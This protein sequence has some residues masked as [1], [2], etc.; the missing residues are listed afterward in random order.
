MASANVDILVN[1][2]N[3]ASGTL[4][5]VKADLSGMDKA[6]GVLTGGI[7]GVAATAGVA[8]VLGLGGAI[9]DLVSKAS[10]VDKIGDSFENL[11]ASAGQSSESMLV[12]LR[13]ASNGMISDGELMLSANKAMMLGVADTAEEMTALLGVARTRGAAMGLSASQAFDNIVTGLGRESALILDNLGIVLDAEK[14]MADYAKTLDKTAQELSSVERKQALVNAVMAQSAGMKAV[15]GGGAG[16]AL[17][18]AQVA[19]EEA[20]VKVGQFMGPAVRDFAQLQVDAINAVQGQWSSLDVAI[21]ETTDLMATAK[22]PEENIAQ[23][24]RYVEV[25]QEARKLEQEGVL[26]V[27]QWS[28]QLNEI[29]QRA[30]FG[31][32]T[33]EDVLLIN[34]AS[35][36]LDNLSKRQQAAAAATAAVAAE[37]RAE[38]TD[39]K[40]STAALAS[41][42]RAEDA[43][44]AAAF[45]ATPEVQK[46]AAGLGVVGQI[47]LQSA[48][49]LNTFNNAVARISAGMAAAN[50]VQAVR[51]SAI[52]QAEAAAQRAVEAGADP[53]QIADQLGAITEQMWNLAPPT[54]KT[55]EG[56]FLFKQSLSAADD[57]LVNTAE[58]LEKANAAA[59][60]LGTE[61]VKQAGKAFEDLKDKVASVLSG[62]TDLSFMGDS[63]D[64]IMPRED[65]VNENARRLGDI[66]VKGFANQDWLEEF[67]REVPDIYAALVDSGDPKGQAA[68]LLKEFQRGMVPE[69]IDKDRAKELVKEMIVGEANAAALAEEIANELATELQMSKEKAL[70]TAQA[71]LGVQADGTAGQSVTAGAVAGVDGSAVAQKLSSDLRKQDNIDL[72]YNAGKASGGTWAAGFMATVGENIPKTLIDVLTTLVSKDVWANIQAQQGL[73]GA[74]P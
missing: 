37:R 3:N 4:K 55:T 23:L 21:R 1:A 41:L 45:R 53:Q 54:D 56:M 44:A 46:L 36:A 70:A 12:A 24:Q 34:Q 10:S 8:A 66:A 74:A 14:V 16:T 62:S 30:Q 68:R 9:S 48:S 13:R 71:A 32:L 35:N 42:E 6:A 25:S 31:F 49:D 7:A 61:G 33:P 11:A 2:K 63:L 28:R 39:L 69:L 60:R 47:A 51:M 58:G 18:Q 22:V 50:Q 52:G 72:L 73:T 27:A 38:T 19:Q 67:K 29:F 5:Q 40:T 65:A 59:T 57:Q 17:A 43:A 64:A 26:G 15:T 20:G